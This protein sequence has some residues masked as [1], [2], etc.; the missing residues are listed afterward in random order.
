MDDEIRRK[1]GKLRSECGCRSGSA[2][3]LVSIGAY[4][5]YAM[6][7]DPVVRSHLERIITG[8]C[9]GLAG[10]LV[11]KVLGMLWARYRYRRLFYEQ[12]QAATPPAP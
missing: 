5:I 2:A 10:G 1:L 3:M 9:V 8:L 4:V 6:W 11:G 7:L 12:V